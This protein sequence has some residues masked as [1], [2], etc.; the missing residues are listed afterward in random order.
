MHFMLVLMLK[1]MLICH[2]PSYTIASSCCAS[3]SAGP[4][5]VFIG[6]PLFTPF[7]FNASIVVELAS[8]GMEAAMA[9]SRFAELGKVMVLVVGEN[10][11][12]R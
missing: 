2:H 1:T 8:S 3:L 9:I 4:T 10:C 5:I 11:H 12:P 6:T 7:P